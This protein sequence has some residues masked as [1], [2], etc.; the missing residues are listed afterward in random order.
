VSVAGT[1]AKLQRLSDVLKEPLVIER[2]FNE[3]HGAAFYRPHGERHVA[4]TRHD[5]DGQPSPRR[6]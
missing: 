5:N 3:I 6:G 4:V 2:L 1:H